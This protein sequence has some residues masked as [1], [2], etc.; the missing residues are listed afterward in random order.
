M[1]MAIGASQPGSWAIGASQPD[2]AAAG[3]DVGQV[4]MIMG[5]ND[6]GKK[7]MKIALAGAC[8]VGVCTRRNFHKKAILAATIGV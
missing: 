1:A 6:N 7:A 3:G 8:M 5:K 4:I 2:V